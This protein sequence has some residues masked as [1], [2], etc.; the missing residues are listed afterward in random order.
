M[1]NNVLI[2]KNTNNDFERFYLKHMKNQYANV[3]VC[4]MYRFVYGRYSEALAKL[5]LK[6]FPS[7]FDFLYQ[8]KWMKNINIYD[9]IIVFDNMY[10]WNILRK[11]RQRN[12]DCRLILWLWNIGENEKALSYADVCEL[13][14]FDDKECQNYGYHKNIQFYFKNEIPGL[15][16]A[17]Y[18]CFF[19]GRD[20]GRQKVLCEMVDEL[21]EKG[22]NA[23]VIIVKAEKKE[24][25]NFQYVNRSIKYKQVLKYIQE[26]NIII[27]AA[28]EN[29]SGET[30]RYLEALAYGKKVITNNL[31]IC[32]SPFYQKERVFIWGKDEKEQLGVFLSK[33]ISHNE[34][35][36]VDTYKIWLTNFGVSL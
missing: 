26:S 35:F 18:D 27:D 31:N 25:E 16:K 29:Q 1:L 19:V 14:S 28:Q 7:L 13:W 12:R 20:K 5:I 22:Y 36:D 34:L 8:G 6:I 33:E 4:P 32:S 9:T 23:K 10:V 24:K 15:N 30:L 21:S 2:L 17:K 3:E 11:I